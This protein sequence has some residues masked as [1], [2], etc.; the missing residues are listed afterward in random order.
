ML[1]RFI[2]AIPHR[3]NVGKSNY[4]ERINT[5]FPACSLIQSFHQALCDHRSAKQPDGFCPSRRRQKTA[6]NARLHC[7]TFATKKSDAWSRLPICA[8]HCDKTSN[9]SKRITQYNH[10]SSRPNKTYCIRFKVWVSKQHFQ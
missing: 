10:R 1:R 5:Q 2:D 7:D 6:V 3:K 4:V 8:K 9:H